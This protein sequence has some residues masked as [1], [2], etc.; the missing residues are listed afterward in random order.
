MYRHVFVIEY[1]DPI[2]CLMIIN[3]I[4]N[5]DIFPK[6]CHD[7]R[8]I[9][10]VLMNA[11]YNKNIIFAIMYTPPRPFPNLHCADSQEYL[12][13]ENIYISYSLR[14]YSSYN[15]IFCQI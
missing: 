11:K 2:I 15:D 12:A 10:N 3:L 8:I 1:R 6:S 5:V 13:L 9:Y 4:K 7:T 14:G